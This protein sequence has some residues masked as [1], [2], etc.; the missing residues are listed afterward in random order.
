RRPVSRAEYVVEVWM[1]APWQAVL[2]FWFYPPDHPEHLTFRSAW[3]EKDPAFDSDIRRRFE[4]VVHQALGGGLQDWGDD[5]HGELAR[6][7]LL[8]QFPRNIW[9]DTDKAF[10][11]DTQA[12]AYALAMVD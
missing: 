8:D 1:Q 6:I 5:V 7:L 4:G 11:G 2:D 9:R 3:F 10:A 12:L